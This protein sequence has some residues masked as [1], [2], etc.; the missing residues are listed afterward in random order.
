MPSILHCLGISFVRK[1]IDFIKFN[2]YGRFANR[3]YFIYRRAALAYNTSACHLERRKQLIV[4]FAVEPDLREGAEL[5]EAKSRIELPCVRFGS[6][7]NLMLRKVRVIHS[8]SLRRVSPRF[9]S[10]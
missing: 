6:K 2:F 7:S 8:R 5:G 4:A 3:P 10:G 1:R 9:R